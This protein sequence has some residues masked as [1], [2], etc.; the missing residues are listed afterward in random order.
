MVRKTLCLALAVLAVGSH[1]Q[2][3]KAIIVSWDGAAD[4]VVDRLLS[5][6]KLPNLAKMAA[7]GARAEYMVPGNPSKTAVGHAAIWTGNWGDINGVT[8]NSVPILPKS[9]HTFMETQSGFGSKALLV[10]PIYLTAAKQGKKVAVL[11]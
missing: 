3:Q 2:S 4:W 11:S 8:G 10:E 7:Q 5:E 1:A 9:A 6:N